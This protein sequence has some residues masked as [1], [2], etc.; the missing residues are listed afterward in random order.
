LEGVPL[1]QVQKAHR[2]ADRREKEMSELTS[3]AM[4]IY[5][6]DAP[7]ELSPVKRR[8]ER[9]FPDTLMRYTNP[10]AICAMQDRHWLISE[11]ERL[12]AGVRMLENVIAQRPSLEPPVDLAAGIEWLRVEISDGEAY[13]RDYPDSAPELEQ[14]AARRNLLTA[15]T[16]ATNTVQCNCAGVAPTMP[17]Y[18]TEHLPTCPC[19]RLPPR[20]LYDMAVLFDVGDKVK[21][22][23]GVA[24]RTVKSRHV[25]YMVTADNERGEVEFVQ[26]HLQLIERATATKGSA[27]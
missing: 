16:R 12:Q 24:V 22:Q 3:N 9:D 18:R 4:S 20:E 17:T 8:D 26:E 14:Q 5:D 19:S 7:L 2:H 13:L 25:S 1:L 15:I 10:W 6:I 21:L 23:T 11:V 27:L